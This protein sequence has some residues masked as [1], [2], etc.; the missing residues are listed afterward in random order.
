MVAMS[1]IKKKFGV[2]NPI[3][4]ITE[5]GIV[6][7]K[8]AARKVTLAPVAIKGVRHERRTFRGHCLVIDTVNGTHYFKQSRSSCVQAMTYIMELI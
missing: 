4:V 7:I 3:E 1:K 8:R 2:M 5:H 6:T